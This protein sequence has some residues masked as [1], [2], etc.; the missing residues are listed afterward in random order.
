MRKQGYLDVKEVP[1]GDGSSQVHV[2]VRRKAA[3]A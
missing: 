2:Y 1:L 3:R